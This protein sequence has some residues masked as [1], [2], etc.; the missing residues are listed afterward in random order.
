MAW[1]AVA[2]GTIAA[3]GGIGSAMMAN[4]GGGTSSSS[5]PWS[6]QQPYLTTGFDGAQDAY[7][8]AMSMGTYQGQTVAG[9]NPYQTSGADAAGQYA[10]QYGMP[11]AQQLGTAGQQFLGYGQQFGS[12]AS[13]LYTQA[14]GDPT[15]KILSDANAYANNPYVDG[16]IDAA[17]RD[18]SR[19]LN[20]TAL[21]S[22][23]R[24]S[25]GTGNTN[26]TRDGVQSA[27]LQRGAADRMADTASSI[28]SQFF[29]QGL[30]MAQGQ[31]NQNLQNSLQAN[32]QLLQSF[33]QGGNTILQ[34]QQVAGN[35][36]DA[37]QAAG[38]VYQNQNQAELNAAHQK[39]LDEQNTGLDLTGKYQGI[40]NG[41]FGTQS[42][43]STSQ[44][45]L[46]AGLGTAASLAGTWGKLGGFNTS[47]SVTPW[48]TS[49][50]SYTGMSGGLYA[51]N[52]LSGTNRGSGD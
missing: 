41:N 19:D 3:V 22:L 30:N 23:A 46:A 34:G 21:P 31:Y 6:V 50:N 2:G 48:A 28:R 35:A 25:S 51:N 29:G 17:N 20:E 8:K 15:Q 40:V 33:Q 24:T 39:F 26:S 4:K 14:Q 7:Q 38:G 11:A 9:L 52:D 27:I 13:N 32:N 12:N 1:A 16:Q 36:F 44:N 42:S 10:S 49:G 5:A 47:T 45:P 37:S 18:V 43:T